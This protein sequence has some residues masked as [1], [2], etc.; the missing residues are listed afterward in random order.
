MDLCLAT[1]SS[2]K[3]RAFPG[4]YTMSVPLG[5]WL[6]MIEIVLDMTYCY[7]IMHTWQDEGTLSNCYTCTIYSTCV[8]VTESSGSVA[9]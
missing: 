1:P 5:V 2:G 6:P 7:D 8:A 3:C 4:K 9:L